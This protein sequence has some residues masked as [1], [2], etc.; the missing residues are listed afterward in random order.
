MLLLVTRPLPDAEDTAKR[1]SALGHEVLVQPFLRIVFAPPPRGLAEPAALIV[2]SRNAL[3]A[4]QAWPQAARWRGRPLFAVGKA[5]VRAAAAAGFTDVRAGGGDAASLADAIRDDLAPDAGPLLYPAARQ[6]TG[7][8]AEALAAAG[9][10][11]ET[12]ETYRAEVATLLD[13]AVRRALTEQALDGVLIYS[14]RTAEAFRA[15]VEAAGI[16]DPFNGMTCYVLSPEIGAALEGA[17]AA[18]K[19][20]ERPEEDLL[21]ALIGKA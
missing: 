1:L 9:Y 20:P 21:L 11:V 4:M 15:A 5:T 12:V 2:T 13:A 3:R 6:R 17:G 16:Y 14:R 19:W 8:L 10:D 7:G 18:V